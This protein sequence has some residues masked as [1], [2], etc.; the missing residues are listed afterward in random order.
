MLFQHL[1]SH[2]ERREVDLR[3]LV[4]GFLRMAPDVAIV[5]GSATVRR[6]ARQGADVGLP[7][8]LV[9]RRRARTSAWSEACGAARLLRA[10]LRTCSAM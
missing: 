8:R 4:A 6:P 1:Q 3:R 10:T 7:F 2:Y 9:G 5:S